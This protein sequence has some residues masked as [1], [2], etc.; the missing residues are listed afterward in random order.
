MYLLGRKQQTFLYDK[1]ILIIILTKTFTLIDHFKTIIPTIELEFSAK[2][3]REYLRAFAEKIYIQ[4]FAICYKKAKK[5][6]L[7][8][9]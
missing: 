8:E 5:L 3:Q 9:K 7:A 2:T 1:H 6:K 4:N